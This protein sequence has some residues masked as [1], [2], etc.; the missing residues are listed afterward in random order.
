MK[1]PFAHV[2]ASESPDTAAPARS[3]PDDAGYDLSV[4]RDMTVFSHTLAAVPTNLAVAIPS[5]FWGLLVGRSSTFYRRGLLVNS[6][7]I[8]AGYRGEVMAL[9]YNLGDKAVL[10]R[11]GE[12][13]FQLIL[14]V[15]VSGDWRQ[16][17]GN[18]L[19]ES[20]RDV[21]GIGSTG[22]IGDGK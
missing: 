10:V 9:V 11:K 17:A 14:I 16:A 3:Y 13:L 12:R 1:I 20:T 6:G 2:R 18:R 19:P 7:V 4:S 15:Q 21:R 8:D 22:G 5:G